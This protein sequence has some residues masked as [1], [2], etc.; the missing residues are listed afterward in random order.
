MEDHRQQDAPT[1]RVE[2]PG[3]HDTERE[4]GDGVGEERLAVLRGGRDGKQRQ[5]PDRPDDADDE[6]RHGTAAGRLQSR[7]GEPAPAEFLLATAE[8]EDEQEL[9]RVH[10]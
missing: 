3:Q 7:E 4:D 2:Q 6:T 1:G 10:G 8:N 5:V 9:D